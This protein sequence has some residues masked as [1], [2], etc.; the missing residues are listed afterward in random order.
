MKW[1]LKKRIPDDVY[2][3]VYKVT[4]HLPDYADYIYIGSKAMYSNRSVK[5]SKKKQTELYKGRGKKPT[6]TRQIKESD[7]ESYTT[8]SKII[9]ELIK[10]HA[11]EAFTWEIIDYGFSKADLLLKEVE[12]QIKYKVFRIEKSFNYMLRA[13]IYKKNLM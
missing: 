6:K 8:S 10:Q 3:F 4:C 13:S 2:G 1:R 7:W 9:N 12:Y 11:I 5:L